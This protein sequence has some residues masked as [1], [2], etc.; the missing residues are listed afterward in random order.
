M[1]QKKKEKINFIKSC[2]Q[3]MVDATIKMWG[4][5]ADNKLLCG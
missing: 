3:F 2:L 5:G 1:S 4:T